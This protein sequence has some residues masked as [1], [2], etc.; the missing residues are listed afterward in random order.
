MVNIAEPAERTRHEIVPAI[1]EPLTKA[2]FPQAEAILAEGIVASFALGWVSH[3]QNPALRQILSQLFDLESAYES[4]V[5]TIIDGLEKRFAAF[6]VSE[7]IS[8]P[9]SSLR[10]QSR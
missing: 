9:A 3:E 8:L 6:V 5:D 10:Q 7:D 4:G 1:A 2:G